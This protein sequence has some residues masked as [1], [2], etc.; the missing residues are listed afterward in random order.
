MNALVAFSVLTL[1]VGRQ[2]GPPACKIWGEAGGGGHCL[3]GIEWH[4][5]GWSVCLPLLIFPCTIKSRSSLL[6]PAHPGGPGKRAVKRMCVR[7]CY[8]ANHN[9]ILYKSNIIKHTEF[10][11]VDKEAF[12]T[13]STH[14]T[15]RLVSILHADSKSL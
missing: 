12:A 4:P 13:S 8:M 2:E 9:Q 14:A 3:V 1:L 15:K 11:Q 7:V 6:A 10:G 5:A